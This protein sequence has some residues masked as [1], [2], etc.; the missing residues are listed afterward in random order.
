MNDTYFDGLNKKL[1]ESIP[2]SSKRILELGCANGKLGAAYK[3]KNIAVHWTAVDISSDA[4][5]KASQVLD[6]VMQVDLN[7]SS[8]LDLFD[9]NSFDTIVIGDLL[10]HLINPEKLISELFELSSSDGKIICCL[11]NM[12][13]LSVVQKIISGDITY[14]EMGLLDKTHLRFFSQPSVFKLFLDGGWLPNLKDEYRTDLQE[15]QF[16]HGV[17][18]AAQA[19]GIPLKTALKKLSSYQMIIECIKRVDVNSFEMSDPMT[20]SVVVPVSR[21][22]EFDENILKSPGLREINAEIVPIFN[23]ASAS[24]AYLFGRE[25]SLNDWV[26]FAHQDVY[27]PKGAGHALVAKLATSTLNGKASPPIGFAGIDFEN[28][29]EAKQSGLVIDRSALFAHMPSDNAIS[30]D[31]FAVLLHKD[32]QL[33]IDPNLGWHTWGTDLCLQAF[34]RDDVDNAKILAI[35]FFHNSLNDYSLS[36]T[37]HASAKIL[38][39]KWPKFHKIETLCGPIV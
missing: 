29:L 9:L 33:I 12:S 39:Q 17:V 21:K 16:L 13:H 32:S 26:L 11:P 37:Y 15:T 10:E 14:D 31:E 23:A 38:K 36:D 6:V 19:L 34:S 35:P 25:K 7:N 24:E 22:W 4:L 5:E 18:Y 28:N 8:L 27:I 30:I 1:F 2:D 20:I 3:S